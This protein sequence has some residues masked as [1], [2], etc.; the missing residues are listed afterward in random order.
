MTSKAEQL[1]IEG[2]EMVE[3][4][5]A[6]FLTVVRRAARLH[7]HRH[8]YV[9]TDDLHKYAETF[10]VHPNHPNAWGA[11]FHGGEWETVGYAKSQRP[12]SHAR[13]IRKWTLRGGRTGG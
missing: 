13:M 4:H 5:N 11:V 12:K 7:V 10:G 6:D 1:K 8:G 3:E 9:T 2:I